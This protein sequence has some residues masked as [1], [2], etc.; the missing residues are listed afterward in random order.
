MQVQ[1]LP[2]TDVDLSLEAED[3][4]ECQ[5]GDPSDGKEVTGYIEY[6]NLCSCNHGAIDNPVPLCETHYVLAERY[7][8]LY[9]PHDWECPL[10][11][12]ISDVVGVYR[13]KS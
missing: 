8:A 6:V 2:T 13:H 11:G 7:L 12:Y 3:T 1:T 10:C 5:A 9:G 4:E